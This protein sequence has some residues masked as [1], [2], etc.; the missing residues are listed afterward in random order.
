MVPSPPPGRGVRPGDIRHP[1]P[2]SR[3]APP[4]FERLRVSA[5]VGVPA[6]LP[7]PAF[8]WLGAPLVVWGRGR[9]GHGGDRGSG[10]GRG[11]TRH[12]G[13]RCGEVWMLSFPLF[14]PLS[15]P[16]AC[17]CRELRIL[18]RAEGRNGERERLLLGIPCEPPVAGATTLTAKTHSKSRLL[19]LK[20]REGREKRRTPLSASAALGRPKCQLAL[21]LA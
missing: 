1:Q 3:P 15:R 17:G 13:A 6:L 18:G 8:P 4:L 19:P 11:H 20:K 16:R 2:G 9:R 10:G 12:E 21:A 7:S 5:L 14:S